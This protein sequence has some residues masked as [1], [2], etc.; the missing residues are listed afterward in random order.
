MNN[1]FN[2]LLPAPTYKSFFQTFGPPHRY[3]IPH[4][5]C[6][7]VLY[8]VATYFFIGPNFMQVLSFFPVL[9]NTCIYKE[10]YTIKMPVTL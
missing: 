1:I 10:T 6:L 4:S 2:L 5:E 3:R 9:L 8:G 7:Q